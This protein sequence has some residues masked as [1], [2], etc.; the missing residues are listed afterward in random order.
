MVR[1]DTGVMDTT[2]FISAL[3]EQGELLALAADGIGL[4]N[5]V[6]T[7]PDWNLRDLLEHVGNVHRWATAYV[8][9]GRA[10][11]L[12][13]DE[14]RA[15]FESGRPTDLNIVDWFRTGHNALVE[16]LR[17]APTDLACWT[18]MPARSPPEFWARRQA[19]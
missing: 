12:N 1:G 18:F 6:P 9:S 5:R 11:M 3:G 4:D 19:H 16:A 17:S 13:E 7:C 8:K 14:A 10:D 15:L 2:G